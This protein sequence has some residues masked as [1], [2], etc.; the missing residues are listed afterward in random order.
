MVSSIPWFRIYACKTNDRMWGD[1]SP[2][3]LWRSEKIWRDTA[4]GRSIL[5][6]SNS[7]SDLIEATPI[8]RS[9]SRPH[10]LSASSYSQKRRSLFASH[11]QSRWLTSVELHF[12]VIRWI[13]SDPSQKMPARMRGFQIDKVQNG[14]AGWTQAKTAKRLGITQLRVSDLLSGKLSKFSLDA[15]VNML[16]V[17]GRKVKLKV[18]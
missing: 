17:M 14:E 8:V 7:R 12:L 6:H 4:N 1:Y 10:Q 18:A 9:I 16:A 15:L 13:E 11:R 5:G 2:S 3:L